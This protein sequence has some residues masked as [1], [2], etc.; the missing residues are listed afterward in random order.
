MKDFVSG[1]KYLNGGEAGWTPV[2]RRRS[3]T[4]IAAL[5]TAVMKI[6]QVQEVPEE[7]ATS[8]GR[9]YQD[10]EYSEGYHVPC[11]VEVDRTESY[12]SAY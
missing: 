3:S 8:G 2:K 9:E 11:Q 5:S 7:S 4:I 10:Y 12:C 1:V 6:W